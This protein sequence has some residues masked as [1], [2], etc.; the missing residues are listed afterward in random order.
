[1]NRTFPE[2]RWGTHRPWLFRPGIALASTRVGALAVRKLTPLDRA[3]MRRSS[4]R[5]TILGPLALPTVLL[6]TTG[7][8]SGLPRSSPLLCL[9]E[10]HR[11]IIVGSNFGQQH[12]PAWTA[13]LLADPRATATLGGETIPVIATPITEPEYA[14]L[15]G[16]FIAMASNY[17]AYRQRTSRPLRMFALTHDT[18]AR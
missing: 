4:G 1:M 6:T 9:H 8:K 11:L 13:N 16:R 3:V 17:G 18:A 10:G 7:R 5:F 15:Y 14:P 2:N 12:H